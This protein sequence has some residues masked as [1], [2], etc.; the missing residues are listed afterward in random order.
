[1]QFES[2]YCA[3]ASARLS[4]MARSISCC[5]CASASRACSWGCNEAARS[6]WVG[7]GVAATAGDLVVQAE[8]L[9]GS[10]GLDAGLAAPVC[11]SPKR[12]E[13]DS[14]A[15]FD[16]GIA[17]HSGGLSAPI[18]LPTLE[19]IEASAGVGE[20]HLALRGTLT[21]RTLE[22]LP[23]RS[24]LGVVALDPAC[25][26]IVHAREGGDPTAARYGDACGDGEGEGRKCISSR[27]TSSTP[28][29][30]SS[31]IPHLRSASASASALDSASAICSS[32]SASSGSS[33]TSSGASIFFRLLE[34][35]DP[36]TYPL[37]PITFALPDNVAAS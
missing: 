15:G 12:G 29:S 22:L 13:A 30:S 2:R 11:L 4:W 28:K 36:G 20:D 32:A 27:S 25:E 14:D 37:P 31:N 10:V 5:S 9:V 33:T 1:M 34:A 18:L 3:S 35:N 19:T 17:G 7:G 6:D 21:M 23:H 8:G 24:V 16:G 26:R